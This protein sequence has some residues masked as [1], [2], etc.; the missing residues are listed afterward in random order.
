MI[1]HYLVREGG[2]LSDL[3]DQDRDSHTGLLGNHICLFE[4]PADGESNRCSAIG[5][6][7]EAGRNRE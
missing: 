5:A 4:S 2:V 3:L 6:P 1:T 7:V